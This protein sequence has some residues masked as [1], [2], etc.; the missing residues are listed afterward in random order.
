MNNEEYKEIGLYGV[1]VGGA[2][3]AIHYLQKR[4]DSS[5]KYSKS[6]DKEYFDLIKELS[7]VIKES[8]I[9]NKLILEM[10]N[11]ILL[12]LDKQHNQ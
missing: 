8:N 2:T 1:I 12:K 6:R 7:G 5:E 9:T 4:L 10:L 11:E 3:K